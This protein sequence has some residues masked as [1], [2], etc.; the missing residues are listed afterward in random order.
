MKFEV[1]LI[2]GSAGALSSFE[3]I[4]DEIKT[5]KKVPIVFLIHMAER[6]QSDLKKLYSGKFDF[7]FR[8]AEDLEKLVPGVIYFA[9]TMYHLQ[10]ERNFTFSFSLSEKVHFSR[11]AID[12]LFETAAEAYKDKVLGII[13]SGASVD[14][15]RGAKRIEDL[16]GKIIVQSPESSFAKTMPNA[17]LDILNKPHIMEISD[18][19]KFINKL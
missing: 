6:K 9:P 17:A 3:K 12:V 8:E 7:R 13:L 1:V 2:G 5:D 18:I 16:G 11:P 10:I 19:G 14:G 15:A 4:L